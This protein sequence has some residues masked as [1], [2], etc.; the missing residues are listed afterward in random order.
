MSAELYVPTVEQLLDLYDFMIWG[1]RRCLEVA[2]SVPTE[3]LVA[4]QGMSLGSVHKLLVHMM[5]S[6]ITWLTRLHGTS[7]TRMADHTDFPTLASVESRWPTVHGELLA[8]IAAQTPATLAVPLSYRNTQ[9]QTLSFPL[10]QILLHV[11]D[12]ATYHRGQMNSMARRVA[13]TPLPIMRYTYLLER[14]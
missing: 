3:G 12:H 9:G 10:G 4:E 13:G 11:A 14:S 7:P 8:F 6:Q 5:S 2:R 1:D